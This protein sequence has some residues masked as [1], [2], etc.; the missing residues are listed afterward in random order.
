MICKIVR[1][2]TSLVDPNGQCLN[3]GKDTYLAFPGAKTVLGALPIAGTEVFQVLP[4][5]SNANRSLPVAIAMVLSFGAACRMR[6]DF[7]T[8]LRSSET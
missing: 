7:P 3:T 1:T 2:I 8:L 6:A 4:G 5:S